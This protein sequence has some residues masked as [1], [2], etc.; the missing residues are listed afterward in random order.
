MVAHHVISRA[1]EFGRYRGIADVAGYWAV[2]TAPVHL[3]T[4]PRSTSYRTS[5]SWCRR[6]RLNRQVCTHWH[7]SWSGLRCDQAQGGFRQAQTRLASNTRGWFRPDHAPVQDQQGRQGR[8][9][10]GPYDQDRH[11]RHRLSRALV[12]AIGLGANRPQDAVYP[13]SL[14]DGEGRKYNGENKYV[15]HFPEGQ[16]PPAQGFWSL[17]MYDASYFFVNNPLNRYSISA[18][19]LQ[20]IPS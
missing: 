2:S 12:T 6:M 11:L 7:R 15:M 9:R 14:K 3:R 19:Q 4:M 5:S 13:T 8:E 18:R 1:A 20:V 17:T 10:L 16:L